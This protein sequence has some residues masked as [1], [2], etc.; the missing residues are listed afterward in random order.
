MLEQDF[1]IARDHKHVV[2][3]GMGGS[4]LCP[5][6]FREV[7]KKDGFHVLDSTVPAAI[8]AVERKIDLNDTLFIVASKSGSTI[9]PQMLM[10]YFL[11]RAPA[12]NF[13]AITDPGSM[14][15]RQAKELGFRKVFSGDPMI[16]GRFSAF[17]PFGLVPA[18]IMGVDIREMLERVVN[19]D[20]APAVARADQ[21]ATMLQE[22][23][24]KMMLDDHP[25]A[26]WI[27]QLV[28]ESTGK[29]GQGILPVVGPQSEG[30]D[31]YRMA[32]GNDDLGV[33][34]YLWEI[35]TALVGAEMK[36]NPFDQPNV[37][38]SKD[39][40]AR[41]L[42]KDSI[43]IAEGDLSDLPL[44]EP[45][46]YLAVLSYTDAIERFSHP[47]VV[48]TF[49]LGPR[50]LHSTGQ[51][52]KGGP[53]TGVFIQ[54]VDDDP[55]D[56]PIP[57]QSYGFSFLKNAQAAGDYEALKSRGRKIIRTTSD[58]LRRAAETLRG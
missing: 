11:S 38:E 18:A 32:L 8:L 19:A 9:E 54:I 16:G 57:G 20:L 40:T 29:E 51:L 37:Q 28:A 25:I 48:T 30:P 13:I 14:L 1:E 17:S 46:T 42:K 5:L 7:F 3:L 39:A 22:G 55:V 41:F 6:V 43:E 34:M 21:M 27:E 4:S 33:E 2:L 26:S 44:L 58:G 36:I 24:D 23:R 52:H 15:E 12:K 45:P 49:G 53:P 56:V 10:K 35:A 31:R 47:R 50:Y